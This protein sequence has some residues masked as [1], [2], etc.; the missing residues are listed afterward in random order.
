VHDWDLAAAPV[1]ADGGQNTRIVA[2]SKDGYVYSIDPGSGTIGWHT[3]VTTVDAAPQIPSPGNGINFCPG[4]TG[5]VEWNGPAYSQALNAVFSNG[6]DI[7][8]MQLVEESNFIPYSEG[9]AQCFGLWLGVQP[10]FSFGTPSSNKSGWVSALDASSG[11]VRWKYHSPTPMI[12]GVTVTASGLLFTGD[13]NGNVLVLD[14]AS[15]STVKSIST[16]EPI[17]GGVI[18]YAINGKQYVAVAAGIASKILW[19]PAQPNGP[20]S[21]VVLGL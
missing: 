13:L 18:S 4:T 19:T 16:G 2:G 6:V 14:A 1:L 7:C 17:G 11:A 5:G 12:A 21:I 20:S 8:A 9:A 15:G 3:P 10:C